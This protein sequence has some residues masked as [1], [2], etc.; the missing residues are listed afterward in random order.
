MERLLT[1]AAIGSF[2]TGLACL[3]ATMVF[4]GCAPGANDSADPAVSCAEEYSEY[5]CEGALWR[6]AFSVPK[7]RGLA[8]EIDEESETPGY[9]VP[10][11]MIGHDGVYRMF[12]TNM[13]DQGKKYLATSADGL[14]W[15]FR[16]G[17]VLSPDM[18]GEAVDGYSIVDVAELYDAHGDYRLVVVLTNEETDLLAT[19]TSEDGD[20]WQTGEEPPY[21]L[22]ETDNGTSSVWSVIWNPADGRWLGYYVGDRTS[23]ETEDGDGIRVAVSE[24]G[25]TFSPLVTENVLP[26]HVVDPD[27]VLLEGGGARL[28]VYDGE[29]GNLGYADTGE[30]GVDFGSDYTP[31]KGLSGFCGGYQMQVGDRCMFDQS[32]LRLP[33]DSI[34]MYFGM[35]EK[36]E[37]HT[38]HQGLWRARAVD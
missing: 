26:P 4:G 24:N 16:E 31:L 38:V 27:A 34:W 21:E 12:I 19:A 15:E 18:F 10:H 14:N 11:I 9:S 20:S 1:P 29:T 7:D 5:L 3:V 36:L 25:Q 28:Y 6:H 8:W 35:A 33:D 22:P 17:A 23:G 13:M 32:F 2:I 30:D 37:E